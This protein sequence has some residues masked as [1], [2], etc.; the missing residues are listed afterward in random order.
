LQQTFEQWC[1]VF[2]ILAATYMCGAMV[3]LIFGT[4]KTLSWNSG[5]NTEESNGVQTNEMEAMKPLKS[6]SNSQ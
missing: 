6:S 4:A 1:I 5:P 2:W 3:F